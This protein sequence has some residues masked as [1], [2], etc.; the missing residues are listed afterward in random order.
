MIHTITIW[1]GEEKDNSGSLL[2]TM[3]MVIEV[4][5]TMVVLLQKTELHTLLLK[6]ETQL[7][8]ETD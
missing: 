4:V 7:T 5:S 6:S 2:K 3:L 1:D 8:S